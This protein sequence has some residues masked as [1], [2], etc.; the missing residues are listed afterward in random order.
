MPGTD[1]KRIVKVGMGKVFDRYKKKK[2]KKK[3]VDRSALGHRVV[4][5]N[6][7]FKEF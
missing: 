3:D 5:S 6:S 2:K 7:A 1:A 4:D